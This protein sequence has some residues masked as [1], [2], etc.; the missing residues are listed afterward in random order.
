MCTYATVRANI[1][2]SAKG[3]G[4]D[5]ART[6]DLTVYFDHPVHAPEAHTVNI[7]ITDA[8]LEPGARVA[9]ELA[10]ESARRLAQ[11][12]LEALQSAPEELNSAPAA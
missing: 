12:I 10:P 8:R 2:C 9:L 1:S 7:D 6:P 3:P 5:W 4:S 11:A